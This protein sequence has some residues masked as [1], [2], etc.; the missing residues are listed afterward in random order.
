MPKVLRIINRLNLGGPTFN[1]GNL[2][3]YMSNEFE[4]ILVA[5]VKDDS[6][7][8]S[9]FI[10][11]DLELKP[12]LIP[13]MKR[14]LDPIKDWSAF[15]KIVKIIKEYR[16]DIVHTHAAKAGTLGRLAAIYCNVPVILHTFHGHVFHSY[17]SPLKT[18]LFLMIERY[19]ARKSTKIIAISTIQ[20]E[21]L[22]KEFNICPPDKIVVVPLGFKLHKFTEDKERKRATFRKQF[23]LAETDIAVGIIG[24]LV[25]IK[26]HK[27]FIKSVQLLKKEGLN[28]INAFIVGDGELK[29]ELINY[30]K[31]IGIDYCEKEGKASINFTSW[32]K[33]IDIVNAGL[34]I[35]TLTSLNE[36]T[37]V[38]L[39]EAQ[40]SGLPIVSTDVGGIKDITI[41]NET[42][43]LVESN[44][45]LAFKEQLSILVRDKEKR[46]KMTKKG[47]DMALKQ[48]SYQRLCKDMEHLYWQLLKD[49]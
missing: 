31:K 41:E 1:A 15:W 24:R 21:E 45:I 14:S 6:E 11:E 19:L 30:C 13:N 18:K 12:I 16:P 29:M 35:M 49:K 4:T 37:P 22:T 26:N 38:T 40:A 44:N 32:I 36:G 33:E 47:T 17:F 42:A 2:T 9:E 5:G 8:S 34:D 28:E 39:I 20:K 10:L 46:E 25:P 7:E 3:R 43:L 27:L 23:Q 48:F